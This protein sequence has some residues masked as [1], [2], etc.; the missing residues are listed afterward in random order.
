MN[1]ANITNND[2]RKFYKQI[3]SYTDRELLEL[4]AFFALQT[5]NNSQSIKFNVQFLFYLAIISIIIAV[6][7]IINS[8]Q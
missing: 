8:K 6:V 1:E 4:Q 3:E 7:I 2:Q 5:K